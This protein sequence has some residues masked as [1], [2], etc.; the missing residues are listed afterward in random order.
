[1]HVNS[2]AADI[3]SHHIVRLEDVAV[4]ALATCRF[5]AVL[6][7]EIQEKSKAVV[8]HLKDQAAVNDRALLAAMDE[9]QSP[10]SLVRRDIVQ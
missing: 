4:C 6:Q 5:H 8:V 10:A 1:M 3:E 9:L 2:L 7:V